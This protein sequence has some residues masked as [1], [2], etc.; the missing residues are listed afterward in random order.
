MDEDVLDYG[1]DGEVDTALAGEVLNEEDQTMDGETNKSKKKRKRRK[2]S[3]K[4]DPVPQED[5]PA[6]GQHPSGLV[7]DKLTRMK[8]AQAAKRARQTA[9]QAMLDNLTAEAEAAIADDE[10]EPTTPATPAEETTEPAAEEAAAETP[11]ETPA[12]PTPKTAPLGSPEQRK[13]LQTTRLAA[14]YKANKKAELEQAQK[15]F[16]AKCAELEAA[17]QQLADLQKQEAEAPAAVEPAADAQPEQQQTSAL[18]QTLEKT[19]AQMLVMMRNFRKLQTETQHIKEQN[20]SL[21]KMCQELVEAQDTSSADTCDAAA[22]AAEGTAAAAAAANPPPREEDPETPAPTYCA[23]AVKGDQLASLNAQV[24]SLQAELAKAKRDKEDAEGKLAAIESK[25]FLQ[26][27]NKPST[28]TGVKVTGKPVLSVRDWVMSVRDYTDSLQ[29]SHDRLRVAV[30]ESYLGGDAKRDWHTK[31]RILVEQGTTI[32]FDVFT[33]AVIDSW[34]PACSDVKARMNLE[35]LSYGGNMTQYVSQFDRIC[36]FVPKMTSDERVH[37]FLFQ[38][39]RTHPHVAAELQ[40]DPSTKERWADYHDLRK[41]A[42]HAAAT[43]ALPAA[44]LKLKTHAPPG[45]L[46]RAADRAAEAVGVLTGKR[47][48][49]IF[50]RLGDHRAESSAAAAGRQNREQQ[51]QQQRRQ[52]RD[53]RGATVFNRHSNTH[54]HRTHDELKA[55]AAPLRCAWCWEVTQHTPGHKAETCKKPFARENPYV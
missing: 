6:F 16:Q 52:G 31:R 44:G 47:P 34:D 17:K 5:K 33:T 29:L 48:R 51:Q 21:Q 38:I 24:A 12:A 50:E 30:A 3:K 37:K 13:Q 39:Q 35:K 7:H 15:T 26:A 11:A 23:T 55:M 41:Y 19:Q 1:D 27:L 43:D 54:M 53:H 8:R 32:T 20:A 25:T 18:Q 45:K 28:F 2:S 14:K 36:S 46:K 49:T 40:T 42:L 9:K 10:L 4:A 22:A